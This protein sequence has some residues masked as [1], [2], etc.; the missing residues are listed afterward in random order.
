MGSDYMIQFRKGK[1]NVAADAFSRYHEEGI[2]AA[3]ST[4]APD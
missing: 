3:I 2:A 4:M 1:E